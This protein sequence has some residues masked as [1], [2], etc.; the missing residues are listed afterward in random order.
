VD[1]HDRITSG[2]GRRDD[3]GAGRAIIV[4]QSPSALDRPLDRIEKPLWG[5]I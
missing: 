2:V 5:W 1:Q 3:G 4:K